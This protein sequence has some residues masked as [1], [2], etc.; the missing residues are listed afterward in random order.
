MLADPATSEGGGE[1][2]PS[3]PACLRGA[4]LRLSH[5]LS[6]RG[7][8]ACLWPSGETGKRAGCT[9]FS[10]IVLWLERK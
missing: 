4:G 2:S 5:L 3:G 6:L 10:A 7:Q 9:C 8:R 1:D